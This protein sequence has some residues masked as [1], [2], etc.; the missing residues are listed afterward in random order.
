MQ[1]AERGI[2]QL[3]LRDLEELVARVGLEDVLERFPCMT[4]AR[5]PGARLDVRHLAAQHGDLGRRRVIRGV[6]IKPEEAV[7]A[8]DLAALVVTLD[9][10]VVEIARA[11]HCRARVRL[12]DDDQVLHARIGPRLRRELREAR[13]DLRVRLLAQDAERRAAQHLQ[14]VVAFHRH[15]VVAAIAEERE[16]V[17]RQP[18]ETRARL[19][20]LGR[21]ERRGP[22]VQIGDDLA[23]LGEH[24][25][26][27]LDSGAQ[28]GQHA[29][30]IGCERLHR[31]RVDDAIHLDM[32]IGCVDDRMN[33]EMQRQP[34]PVD[35]HRH[36]V[37]QK[38]HVVVDDLDH[39]VGRAPAVLLHA[40]V[41]DAHA[42]GSRLAPPREVPVR[43]RGAVKV[44]RLALGEILG[45]DLEV[46]RANEG[47]DGA[48]RLR[49]DLLPDQGED[50]L[51]P[52]GLGLVG[53]RKHARSV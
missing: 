36:A 8:A 48:A 6:G 23:Q 9:A 37:D 38:R 2:E 40:G 26:P 5:D 1:D 25:F 39:G 16:M 49:G 53:A 21:S 14:R 4:A 22:A 51:E 10:D 15:Q 18:L 24:L 30:Q 45:I 20:E 28:V 19:G 27:V 43:Q 32:Q 3:L 17:I 33:D 47:L 52:F 31:W 7:L 50:L 35:F 29:L 12:G 11:V 44:R 42:R 46:I 41:E 34:M 13:R